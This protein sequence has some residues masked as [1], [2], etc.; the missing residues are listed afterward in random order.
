MHAVRK[1]PGRFRVP[2][3]CTLLTAVGDGDGGGGWGHQSSAHTGPP[4]YSTQSLETGAEQQRLQG[5]ISAFLVTF[6]TLSVTFCHFCH[7]CHFCHFHVAFAIP[8]AL[9][10]T[11]ATFCLLPF[12]HLRPRPH[13]SLHT[14][15]P[16]TTY[17]EI[18]PPVSVR[19]IDIYLPHGK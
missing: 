17:P 18:H 1:G 12:S 6:L 13:S 7:I 9:F 16:F 2:P 5:H 15:T 14:H 8:M 3:T 11:F 4:V 10:A 19:Y